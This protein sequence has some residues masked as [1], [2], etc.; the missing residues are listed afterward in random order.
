MW[1]QVNVVEAVCYIYLDQLDWA[2]MQA[3]LLDQLISWFGRGGS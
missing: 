3:N 1:W 2:M